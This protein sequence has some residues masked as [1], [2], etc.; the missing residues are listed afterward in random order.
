MVIKTLELEHLGL[1][2][3]V[4]DQLEIADGMCLAPKNRSQ[5]FDFGRRRIAD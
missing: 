3:G 5:D 2:A 4:F 1:V